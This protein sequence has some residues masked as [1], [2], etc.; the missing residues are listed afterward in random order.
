[1]SALVH[2]MN[3]IASLTTCHISALQMHSKVKRRDRSVEA[4]A[5]HALVIDSMAHKFMTGADC[6]AYLEFVPGR[7][8]LFAVEEGRRVDLLCSLMTMAHRTLVVVHGAALPLSALES[9]MKDQDVAVDAADITTD[10]AA[11]TSS[12]YSRAVVLASHADPAVLGA[13]SKVLS[14]GSIITI[15]LLGPQQVRA[16]QAVKLVTA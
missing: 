8:C 4:P 2:T 9:F 14:P 6:H 11:C 16:C 5:V 3:N 12:I 10:P 15:R 7:Y 1:M 13:T